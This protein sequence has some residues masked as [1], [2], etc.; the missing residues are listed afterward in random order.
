M[1]HMKDEQLLPSFR[2]LGLGAPILEALTAVGY[3]SPSPVQAQT[4]PLLLSRQSRS[5]KRR[6][7]PP[8]R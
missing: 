6:G 8:R 2:E 5:A 1:T 4:I 3:E 7:K